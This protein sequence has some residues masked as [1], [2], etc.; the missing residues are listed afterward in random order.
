MNSWLKSLGTASAILVVMI[1]VAV[2]VN[3]MG[4]AVDGV[5]P[6]GHRYLGVIGWLTMVLTCMTIIIHRDN[7][8]MKRK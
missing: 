8:T 1:V 4:M 3:L 2:V 7:V 6:H 5:I